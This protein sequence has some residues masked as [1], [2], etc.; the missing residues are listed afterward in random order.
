MKKKDMQVSFFVLKRDKTMNDFQQKKYIPELLA[1][2]GEPAAAY[3][4]F[5]A[6]ADAVYLGSSYS[7]RAYAKNFTEEELLDVIKYAHLFK[8]KVYLASNILMK[9][10]ELD[11]CVEAI[12][13]FYQSGID[14]IIVQDL[15]LLCALH[16]A[17]PNLPLHGSTQM[18][19]LSKESLPFL[20]SLG[21]SRVVPG[22]ELSINEL[23][24]LKATGMDVECFIHGAMCYSYSGKCLFSSIAGGRSGNRGRCAGPCR[25]MYF[26][27]LGKGSYPISMKDMNSLSVLPKLLD[28]QIDSFKIEGRM[29]DASYAAGVTEIY[30]KYIDRYLRD[31]DYVIEPKDLEI[32]ASL[33]QRSER[34]NGYFELYNGRE[35]ISISSPA[36]NKTSEELVSAYRSKYIDNPCKLS[37]DASVKAKKGEKLIVSVCHEADEVVL[38]SDIFLEKSQK[39]SDVEENIKKH[40]SKFGDTHFALEKLSITCENDE[41]V[42]VSVLKE[43]RRNALLK[44]EDKIAEH[45]KMYEAVESDSENLL[46]MKE[47]DIC[48]DVIETL[49]IGITTDEQLDAVISCG[50]KGDIIIPMFSLSEECFSKAFSLDRKVY[51]RLPEIMRQ[52]H[53]ERIKNTFENLIDRYDFAGFYAESLDGLGFLKQYVS[54]EKIVAGNGIYAMN[55]KVAALLYKEAK[56]ISVPYELNEKEIYHMPTESMELMVYG[57][58]PLMQSANCLSK[59][60]ASCNKERTSISIKDESGR[61]FSSLMHHTLCYNTLYNCVPLCL[62]ANY[63]K[64]KREH[65]FC[66]YRIDFTLEN[67]KEVQD[68]LMAVAGESEPTFAYTTGHIKRGVL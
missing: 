65:R 40:F 6:G 29:K 49:K 27:E 48:G 2:A 4:A 17:Y 22:R 9:N 12:K 8:K 60:L 46:A 39:E 36:Y 62:L 20:K 24:A 28:A 56:T 38:E 7:A 34:Q 25:K 30:R 10:K 42:P 3:G 47:P 32:L 19:I 53:M 68:V 21:V 57:Y 35:M 59:T 61:N 50:M 52:C 45:N 11:S 33:Y 54:S 13:P 16:D 66:S 51:L 14:G 1:P 15:G 43:L 26:D 5:S 44:L 55:Q 31:G 41:F 23:S 64:Y 63:G 58:I 18:T 67:A 37:V